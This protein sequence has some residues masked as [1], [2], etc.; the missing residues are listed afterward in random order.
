MYDFADGRIECQRDCEGSG[1]ADGGNLK[2][3]AEGACNGRPDE[4][5]GLPGCL[6]TRGGENPD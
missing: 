2:R 4:Y 5:E 3:L 6:G 1:Q